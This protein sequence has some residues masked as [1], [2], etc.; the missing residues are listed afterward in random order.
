MVVAFT[1]S[2]RAFRNGMRIPSRYTC[3][4]DDLSPPLSWRDAPSGT[5]SYALI[6][7]DPDSTSGLWTH[8]LVYDIPGDLNKLEEGLPLTE[9]L[10]SGAKQGLNTDGEV[11]YSGP[12]PPMGRAHRY[13]FRILAV[14]SRLPLRPASPRKDLEEALRGL[15]IARAEI[16]GLY[17]RHT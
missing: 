4:G 9:F 8:W 10:P 11:G 13:V 6:C 14:S 17:G 16:V 2:S 7:E 1:I 12:C 5:R 15:V 3:E